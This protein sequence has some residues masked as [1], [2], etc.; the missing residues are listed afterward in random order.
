MNI[1]EIV[2][3]VNELKNSYE[4]NN[5]EDAYLHVE[6]FGVYNVDL[7]LNRVTG[8]DRDVTII[9]LY[10]EGGFAGGQSVDTNELADFLSKVELGHALTTIN[11]NGVELPLKTMIRTAEF[12]GLAQQKLNEEQD[13]SVNIPVGDCRMS[14]SY[15]EHNELYENY[16][17]YDIEVYN[18]EGNTLGK[19]VNLDEETLYEVVRDVMRGT[20]YVVEFDPIEPNVIYSERGYEY[21]TPRDQFGDEIG[22][23]LDDYL[24]GKRYEPF[25]SRNIIDRANELW[26]YA[27]E[28]DA[29][30][31]LTEENYGKYGVTVVIKKDERFERG[32]PEFDGV[33]VSVFDKG[34]KLLGNINNFSTDCLPNEL[35]LIASGDKSFENGSVKEQTEKIQAEKTQNKQNIER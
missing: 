2:A 33:Y 7:E 9:R 34:G 4:Y 29:G 27:D 14:I 12:I 8:D 3:K 20:A 28:L 16:D 19:N 11:N 35:A 30:D 13:A 5:Y 15:S 31:V 17:F 23:V 10:K 6:R 18:A 25:V 22:I 1:D 32:D 26:Y 21:N 24:D